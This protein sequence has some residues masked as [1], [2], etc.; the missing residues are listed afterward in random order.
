MSDSNLKAVVN[1]APRPNFN[2]YFSAGEFWANGTSHV[3]VVK[4]SEEKAAA[5]KAAKKAGEE[6]RFITEAQLGT[7]RQEKHVLSVMTPE[8]AAATAAPGALVVTDAEEKALLEK[9]R[10]E[11]AKASK[12]PEAPKK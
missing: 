5:E 6:R 12:P 11:K 3:E 2:G 8:Q 9:H 10:A 4:G 1:V 7:L